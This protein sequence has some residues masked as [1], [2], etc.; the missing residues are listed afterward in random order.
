MIVLLKRAASAARFYISTIK[1]NAENCIIL[2]CKTF[3]NHIDIDFLEWY[4][5]F[6]KYLYIF[7]TFLRF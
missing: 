1:N 6:E 4:N 3:P 7:V 5:I 2:T